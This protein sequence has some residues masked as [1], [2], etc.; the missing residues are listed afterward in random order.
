[1]SK[2]PS[3]FVDLSTLSNVRLD[4]RYADD[5]ILWGVRLRYDAP[6]VGCTKMEHQTRTID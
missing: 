2:M 5:T 3:E 4:I 1:M 6:C